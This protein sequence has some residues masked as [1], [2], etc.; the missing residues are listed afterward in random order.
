[1]ETGF[2]FRPFYKRVV[3][4]NFRHDKMYQFWEKRYNVPV[5]LGKRFKLYKSY[6]KEIGISLSAKAIMPFGKYRGTDKRPD[7]KFF[8]GPELAFFYK[9]NNH[10]ITAAY[11][12]IDFD[13]PQLN[14]HYFSLKYSFSF[15]IGK[16][17]I[18]HKDINWLR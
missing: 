3:V 15:N 10:Q 17:K 12:Y 9:K 16:T 6:N 7:I 13:V 2:Y 11:D 5:K 14:N 18:K 4:D 8:P 1:M